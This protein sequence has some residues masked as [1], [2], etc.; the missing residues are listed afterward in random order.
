MPPISELTA[1]SG[2]SAPRGAQGIVKEG[3]RSSSIEIVYRGGVTGRPHREHRQ[4]PQRRQQ[5]RPHLGRRVLQSAE[6]PRAARER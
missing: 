2:N 1:T 4:V 3:T 5:H 6:S